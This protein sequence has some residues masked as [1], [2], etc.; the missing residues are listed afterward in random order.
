[1]KERR[2]ASR[3]KRAF[4]L[5]IAFAQKNIDSRESFCSIRPLTMKRIL[6]VDDSSAT[7]ALIAASL[8]NDAEMEI[9]RVSSGLEALKQ[10]RAAPVDLVLTDV[11]MPEIGGL[12]LLRFIKADA[13]LN[14][15]P[16]IVISTE[17]LDEQT[18][19]RLSLAPDDYLA[20]PFT[21]DQ[22]RH[23]INKRLGRK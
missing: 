3:Y 5:A 13:R 2:A 7:R 6:V 18:R 19:G 17:P 1:L 23:I 20:K 11:H 10:L 12:E 9:A 22:L 4:G 14:H 8:S 21:T 15:I 16:V